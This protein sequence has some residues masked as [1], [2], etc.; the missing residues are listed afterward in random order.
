MSL[1]GNQTNANNNGS[2]SGPAYLSVSASIKNKFI[3]CISRE[4]KT[5]T[6]IKRNN[7]VRN[8]KDD[9]DYIIIIAL[10]ESGHV[11]QKKTNI[12]H[13]TKDKLI[14]EMTNNTIMIRLHSEIMFSFIN[15]YETI[16]NEAIDNH[17]D[18]LFYYHGC[19]KL[20]IDMS[21]SFYDKVRQ[22]HTRYTKEVS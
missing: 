9:I 7:R 10:D 12:G 16:I 8:K 14:S 2:T 21:K 4:D 19:N 3:C 22:F 13:H 15:D 11:Y 18:N 1:P 6:E 5:N 17:S 20:E